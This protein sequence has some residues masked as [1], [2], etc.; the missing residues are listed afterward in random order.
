MDNDDYLNDPKFGIQTKSTIDR[1]SALAIGGLAR[2]LAEMVEM[3]DG[4]SRL[5]DHQVRRLLASTHVSE[6][7]EHRSLMMNPSMS[8]EECREKLHEALMS[9]DS[10]ITD[11]IRNDEGNLWSR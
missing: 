3:T 6:H 2:I 10:V 5:T 11:S 1:D 9:I 8:P 7:P 4:S